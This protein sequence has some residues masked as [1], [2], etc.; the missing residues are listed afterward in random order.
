VCGPADRSVG[1]GQQLR[2]GARVLSI[3]RV[4]RVERVQIGGEMDVPVLVPCRREHEARAVGR[5]DGVVVFEVAARPLHRRSAPIRHD[6]E[7][8]LAAI[9]DPPFVVELEP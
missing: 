4:E 3:C 7:D 1:R 9:A 6:R 5:P 8:V 2:F